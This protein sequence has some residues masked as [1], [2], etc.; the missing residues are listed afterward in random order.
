MID[1]VVELEVVVVDDVVVVYLDVVVELEVVFFDVVTIGR[2][3]ILSVAVVVVG[4][5]VNTVVV[6]V[7]CILTSPSLHIRSRSLLPVLPDVQVTSDTI[8]ILSRFCVVSFF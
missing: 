5:V 4:A 1:V 2:L 7:V 3:V 6:V 8:Y